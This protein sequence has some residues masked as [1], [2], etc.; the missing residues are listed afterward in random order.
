[1]RAFLA[2]RWFLL[3][4]A[5]GVALALAWPAG[6]AWAA[7]LDPRVVVAPALFLMA[8][9]LPGRSL[10]RVAVR[11]WPALW[12]VA[13]SYGALPAG[14]WLAGTLVAVDDFRIGLLIIASVPCTLASAVLWTRLG[15]GDEATALL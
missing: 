11:P 14:G 15:G 10:A 5:A 3:T 4:L 9:T 2:R 8:W 12:A 7:G 13:V 1:M 6:L